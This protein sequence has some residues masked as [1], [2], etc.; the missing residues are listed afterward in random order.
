MNSV[1]PL[2][3]ALL[4]VPRLNIDAPPMGI[5]SLKANLEK[6]GYLAHCV[7]LNIELYHALRFDEWLEIDNYFQTDLRY[8]GTSALGAGTRQV[9]FIH[10]VEKR[11]RELK[12]YQKYNDFLT[13]RLKEI[14]DKNPKWIGLS[15]FSVNSI[16]ASINIL[17]LI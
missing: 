6:S 14:L 4:G 17:R 13:T 9:D 5:A 1:R 8:T 12:C 16:I 3:I 15:I 7:D 2:D 11:V 10:V